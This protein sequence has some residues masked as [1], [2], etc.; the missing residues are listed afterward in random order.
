MTVCAG[1]RCLAYCDVTMAIAHERCHHA[2]LLQIAA[3]QATALC[4]AHMTVPFRCMHVLKSHCWWQ[5]MHVAG[6]LAWP[7][8]S[9]H[10]YVSCLQSLYAMLVHDD[11]RA[12]QH[13]ADLDY[14][15]DYMLA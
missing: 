10:G 3:T 14:M 7:L 1:S 12:A 2:A 8:I 11:S 4:V 15:L 5:M 6:Q 9:L 13:T